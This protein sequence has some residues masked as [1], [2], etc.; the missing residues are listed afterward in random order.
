MT[1]VVEAPV[2]TAYEPPPVST[3]RWNRAMV[4]RCAGVALCSLAIAT[5]SFLAEVTVLG[6]FEQSHAQQIEYD[7]F[8]DQLA[9][10]IAP[11]SGYNYLGNPLSLGAPVALLSIPEIGLSEVVDQ[12]TTSGILDEGP[13]HLRNTPMPGQAGVSEIMGREATY[14]GPFRY[15]NQLNT[16]DSF[17]VTTGQGVSTYKVLDV[18]YAGAPVPPTVTGHGYLVM[19]TATGTAFM[20]NDLV[21]VDAELISPVQPNPGGASVATSPAEAVLAGDDGAGT[22]IFW[23]TELLIVATAVIFYLRRTWGRVQTWVVGAPVLGFIGLTL[24]D[25]ISRLLPNLL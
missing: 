13:G 14:G 18:R 9:N 2:G 12:G 17:T 11:I 16:G 7:A 20:P 24:A 22:D 1:I 25:Q 4:S 15:I 3:S 10:G 23:W 8:R 19:V 5:G 6:G 21:W